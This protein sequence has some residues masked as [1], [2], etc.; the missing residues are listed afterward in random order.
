MQWYRGRARSVRAL[1]PQQAAL[2][3]EHPGG[4]LLLHQGGDVV[5]EDA[6]QGQ[7]VLDLLGVDTAGGAAGTLGRPVVL[8]LLQAALQGLG[9]GHGPHPARGEAE[10]A[11]DATTT[12][13]LT[14]PAKPGLYRFYCKYHLQMMEGAV[15]V[16]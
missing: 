14:A 16:R 3:L 8:E 11:V 4:G 13:A 10:E 15:T 12:I 7:A 9:G 5:G 2:E 6:Q 1:Q